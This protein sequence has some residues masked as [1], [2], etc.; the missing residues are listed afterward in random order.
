MFFPFFFKK[1]VS[2]TADITYPAKYD[3]NPEYLSGK[4]IGTDLP[5]KRGRP[6]K[7]V[8]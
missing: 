1:D 7:V 4:T 8:K 6:K 3:K 5:K 2:V